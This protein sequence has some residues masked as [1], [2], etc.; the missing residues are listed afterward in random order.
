VSNTEFFPQAVY[1]P[2]D[3]NQPVPRVLVAPPKYIQGPRVLDHAGRYLSTMRLN[4]VGVLA[5][6]RGHDAQAGRVLRSLSDTGVNC[7][8]VTF[9][10]ECSLQAIDEAA[11]TLRD[12]SVDALIAVG[13]GKCVDAGKCVAY[14][15]DVP[16]VIV[17]TLASNDAPCSAVSVLYT[18]EG[19]DAGVEFFPDNPACVIVDTEVVANA[20][21]RYL[22]AGMGDAMATWYEAKVC[23]ENPAARNVV[24]GRPTLA[25]CALGEI[26]A[27]TLYADGQSASEAVRANSV[28]EALERVV[29]ANTLLSGMGFESGGLA[30]AHGVA[31]GYTRVD[32]VQSDYLH[33]ELVAMG[34]VTQLMML[35]DVDEARRVAEFFARVG[36]PIHF[37]QIGLNASSSASI[38]SVVEGACDFLFIH[39]M[40]FPVTARGVRQ[41][42]LDADELGRGVAQK[43]GDQAYRRV[44][45]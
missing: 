19:V 28:N 17:P 25:A 40:P 37:E 27:S 30:A 32:S 41:A 16:V 34:V 12:E 22:I 26:C 11:A 13:G 7:V 3:D 9:G 18:P 6:A 38:D 10:G 14:R 36:L 15:L 20:S 21:E 31:Q 42:M 5:S 1:S 23:L 35:R 8:P 44:Q 29:E 24:G 43:R 2:A 33:G 4:R 45:A 39:N